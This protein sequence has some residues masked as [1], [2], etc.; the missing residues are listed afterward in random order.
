[1]WLCVCFSSFI[2]HHGIPKTGEGKKQVILW[3]ILTS[4]ITQQHGQGI[5]N[6]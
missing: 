3:V 6:I 1:M 4:Q 2:S 5:H